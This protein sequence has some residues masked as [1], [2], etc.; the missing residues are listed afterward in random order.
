MAVPPIAPHQ[1]WLVVDSALLCHCNQG[2]NV[3]RRRSRW[4]V[5]AGS[6]DEAPIRL[7]DGDEL[8]GCFPH[9]RDRPPS[10]DATGVDV[11]IQHVTLPGGLFGF[12]SIGFVV[13][14]KSTRLN[15]S[16]ANIS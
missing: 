8:A 6:E 4:H 1:P 15:S 14:R 2:V 11:S 12:R 10:Q 9:L 3:L 13:D 5:A 16:H 7:P